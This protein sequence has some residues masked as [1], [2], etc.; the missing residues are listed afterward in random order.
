MEKNRRIVAL[1]NKKK[2]SPDIFSW[3]LNDL[4]PDSFLFHLFTPQS[5]ITA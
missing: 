4:D 5:E 2:N 1:S 3:T